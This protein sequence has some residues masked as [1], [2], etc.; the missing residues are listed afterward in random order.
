MEYMCSSVLGDG[1]SRSPASRGSAALDELFSSDD[2][3][4]LWER[5]GTWRLRSWWPRLSGSSGG[6]HGECVSVLSPTTLPKKIV[7]WHLNAGH[8]FMKSIWENVYIGAGR[9]HPLLVFPWLW[10]T[11]LAGVKTGHKTCQS[12]CWRRRMQ[13]KK[14]VSALQAWRSPGL[15]WCLRKICNLR[16]SRSG[17]CCACFG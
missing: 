15:C 8:S 6:R 17:S 14:T 1:V 3:A 7:D 9:Y 5:W 4:E 10:S 13:M 16:G 2:D 12:Q 11:P